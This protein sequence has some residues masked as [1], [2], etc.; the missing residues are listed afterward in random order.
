MLRSA[1]GWAGDRIVF[2]GPMTML[3]PTREW[4][5]SWT[6]EAP[7]RFSFVNEEKLDGEWAYIDE[8]RFRRTS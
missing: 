5:M 6:K 4:R 7:D 8:W 1:D 3:G 2:T